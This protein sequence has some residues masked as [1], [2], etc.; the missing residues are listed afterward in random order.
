VLGWYGVEVWFV[1]LA[2]GLFVGGCAGGV[3]LLRRR[4]PPGTA[5]PLGPGLLLGTFLALLTA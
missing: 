5:V 2:A 3:V 1:G 4:A